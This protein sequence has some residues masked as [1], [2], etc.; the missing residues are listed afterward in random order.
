MPF[1]LYYRLTR[2]IARLYLWR[3]SFTIDGLH[4]VPRQG[5]AIVAAN[6]PCA[7]DYFVMVHTLERGFCCMQRRENFSHPLVAWW[8]RKV[9]AMPVAAGEDNRA[10]LELMEHWIGEGM[11]HVQGPEGDVSGDETGPFTPGFVRIAQRLNVPIVP[12]AIIGSGDCLA[13]RRRPTGFRQFVPRRA[14]VKLR[15]FP[16]VR[17]PAGV[18]SR[19]DCLVFASAIRATIVEELDAMVVNAR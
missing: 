8:L 11:L 3:V 16:P 18:P 17:V 4:N 6:H 1:A 14:H 5:G 15:F 10:A 13:E 12:L 9:C 7:L 2:L 19:E